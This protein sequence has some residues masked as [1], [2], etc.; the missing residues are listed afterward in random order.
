M[1]VADRKSSTNQEYDNQQPE[2]IPSE[3]IRT[4]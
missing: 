1:T 4:N 3:P 2:Q